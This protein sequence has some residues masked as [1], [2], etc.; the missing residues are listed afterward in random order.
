MTSITA[1]ENTFGDMLWRQPSVLSETGSSLTTSSGGNSN[2]SVD[3]LHFDKENYQSNNVD[4]LSFITHRSDHYH[5]LMDDL[6]IIDEI[7]QNFDDEVE[8]EPY[9]KVSDTC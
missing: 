6:A 3:F 1:D 7:Y 9:G 8:S 4:Q 5:Q 2:A